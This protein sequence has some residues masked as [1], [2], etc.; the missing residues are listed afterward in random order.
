MEQIVFQFNFLFLLL[1]K[2]A[3]NIQVSS[4]NTGTKITS[5]REGGHLKPVGLQRQLS[6]EEHIPVVFDE[7]LVSF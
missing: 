7:R 4:R 6:R 1:N 5:R 3:N 2:T